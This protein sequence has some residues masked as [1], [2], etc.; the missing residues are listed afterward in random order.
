MRFL[1]RCLGLLFAAGAEARPAVRRHA[2]LT[3]AALGVSAEEAEK[4]LVGM[5]EQHATEWNSFVDDLGARS[6]VRKWTRK[7]Q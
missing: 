5:L 1:A 2:A 4:N 7:S 6:F 3:A